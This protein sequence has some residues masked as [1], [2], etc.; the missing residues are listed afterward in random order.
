MSELIAN[1]RLKYKTIW[2]SDV[3]LGSKASRAEYLIDFLKSTECEKLYLV[4]DIIDFWSMQKTM[5]W[6]QS[7]NNVI[8]SILNKAKHGT[9]VIYIPGNHDMLMRDHAGLRFGNL[10]IKLHDVHETVTGQRLL[11][12]HGDEFDQIVTCN[13]LKSLLGNYAYDFLIW[14]NR[15]VNRFRKRAGLPYW[16]LA[17]YLKH[18]SKNATEYIKRFEQAVAYEVKK[19][20][21]DGLVCGHLHRAEIDNIN[22]VL[23]CNDGDWVENCTALVEKEDGKLQLLHWADDKHALKN[24]DTNSFASVED[25]A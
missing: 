22:G 14:L 15:V 16:S 3:H 12:T 9:E 19:R 24:L 4:G 1:P 10:V 8:R 21:V 5:F 7:H 23:Y 20:D 6:P 25:A 2:V 11:V 17:T 18:K 13:K